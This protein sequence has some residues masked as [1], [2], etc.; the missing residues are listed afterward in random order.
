MKK[1]FANKKSAF[2]LQDY[3]I[4]ENNDGTLEYMQWETDKK[5]GKLSWIRGNA[6][7]LGDVLALTSITEEAEEQTFKTEKDVRKALKKL[8]DWWDKTTYYCVL[9]GGQACLTHY[10]VSGKTVEENSEA[11][12][13]LKTVLLEHGVVLAQRKAPRK[14]LLGS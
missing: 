9:L 10:C 12:G 3:A 1:R 5:T 4:L 11:F 13:K 6:M 14:T 2:R 8:P 7:I